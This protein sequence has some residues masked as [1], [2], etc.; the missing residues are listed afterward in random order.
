MRSS[1]TIAVVCARLGFPGDFA[2]RVVFL[3]LLASGPDARHF[4]QD[5]PE[6]PL[7]GEILA[8]MVPMVQ[9]AENCGFSAV[10]VQQG[11]RHFLRGAHAD[12]HGP[13]DHRDSPVA[14]GCGGRCPFVAGRAVF[15]SLLSSG[16][17]ARHL[18][19]YGPD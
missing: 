19:R 9:T 17:D 5:G 6:G 2:P 16:P 14:H 13:L 7:R 15:L 8:D 10:A 4:G 18:G 1:S 12:S 11:R 3:S